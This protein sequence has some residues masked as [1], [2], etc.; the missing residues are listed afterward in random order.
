MKRLAI[1]LC[2]LASTPATFAG[3]DPDIGATIVSACVA[4]HGEG[5][6]KPILN[7]PIIAGQHEDYL[8]RSL[9]AYQNGS[10]SNQVMSAQVTALSR[11]DL[12]NMAAYFAAQPSPLH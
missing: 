6:G 9:I 12:E 10:R 8:L 3:G 4:C 2:A 7:Y 11:E 1:I 5:G